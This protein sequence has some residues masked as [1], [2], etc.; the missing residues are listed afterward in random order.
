MKNDLTSKNKI[1]VGFAN[2]NR[3]KTDRILKK[4]KN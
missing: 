2:V 1:E 4:K 3:E